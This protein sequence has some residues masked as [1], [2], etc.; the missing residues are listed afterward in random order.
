MLHADRA[1]KRYGTVTALDA[2]NLRVEPGETVCLLGANGAGKTTTLNLFLGFAE[3]DEG[4]VRVDGID[5]AREPEKARRLI[6][7]IPENVALY[8]ALTGLENLAYFDRLSGHSQPP[9]RLRELLVEAGLAEDQIS[10]PVGGYSKGMRQ[11]VGLAIAF[12]KEARILLLDEPMSGLDPKA[13]SDFTARLKTFSAAGCAVLMATH[14]IFRAKE[15]A[16]RIGI[17]KSGTLVETIASAGVDANRIEQ[18]YLDH[19][20][21][22]A[23]S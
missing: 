12:A 14:D 3:P 11:K 16:S 7:Y 13:A 19:M 17:M 21:A 9:A 5:P 15:C 23:V 6:A 2:L 8:P 4:A 20:H 10:R 18:I 1:T 22:D